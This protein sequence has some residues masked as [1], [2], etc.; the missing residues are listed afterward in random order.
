MRATAAT[1]HA[2]RGLPANAL[3]QMFGWCNLST[4]EVYIVIQAT[5]SANSTGYITNSKKFS[6]YLFHT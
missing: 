3:M 1:F 6:R 2:A 4:A 5:Q